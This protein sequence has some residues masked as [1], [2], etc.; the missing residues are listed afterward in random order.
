SDH[1]IIGTTL[2]GIILAWNPGAERLYGYPAAAAVGQPVSII[3]PADRREE[4]RQALQA[5][6]RGEPVASI[7]TIRQR[8]DGKLIDVAVWLSPV[9]NKN[10]EIIAVSKI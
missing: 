9:R 7:E 2:D 5:V 4:L 6:R 3:V 8:K 10:G 1:A